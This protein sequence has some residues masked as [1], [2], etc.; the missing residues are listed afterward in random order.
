MQVVTKD[1]LRLWYEKVKRRL[2]KLE[3]EVLQV[4]EIVLGL[5]E[6]ISGDL[7][8]LAIAVHQLYAPDLEEEE[9]GG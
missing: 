3:S 8:T 4:K 1:D 2:V 6:K 9:E 7:N 5:E